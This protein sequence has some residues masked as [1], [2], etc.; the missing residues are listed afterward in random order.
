MRPRGTCR[1]GGA[2]GSAP[3]LGSGAK[4]PG[5]GRPTQRLHEPGP[6]ASRVTR[7]LARDEGLFVNE[8][9][10]GRFESGSDERKYR[11]LTLQGPAGPTVSPPA[12]RCTTF[13]KRKIKRCGGWDGRGLRRS[14]PPAYISF[15][16]KATDLPRPARAAGLDR[17]VVAEG[18]LRRPLRAPGPGASGGCGGPSTYRC[19]QG[20]TTRWRP[21]LPTRGRA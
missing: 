20:R 3:R 21:P 1:A 8:T 11:R 2:R 10:L 12:T 15:D 16:V 17:N 13:L 4:A 7:G 19:A 14:A 18:P 9:W 5:P 6:G